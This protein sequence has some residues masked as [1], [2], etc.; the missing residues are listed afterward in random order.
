MPTLTLKELRAYLQSQSQ[1][2]LV[3]ELEKLYKRYPEIQH[4]FHALLLPSG[5]DAQ[6]AKV[7]S[8]IEKE[9]HPK[10]MPKNPDLRK[11]KKLISDFAKLDPSPAQLAHLYSQFAVGLMEFMESFG[12]QEWYY[13]PF[14][15][16]AKRFLLFVEK[17]NLH[18][19]F[20]GT[21]RELVE[22]EKE[23]GSDMEDIYHKIFPVER[24]STI[25][26]L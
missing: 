12:A 11:I 7:V 13:M 23:Y 8:M 26:D 14:Y 24:V 25:I 2:E 3:L 20:A 9:F 1:A 10:G 21:A 6:F 18:D 15:N 16:A 22:Y 19:A 17:H 4:Y 5:G